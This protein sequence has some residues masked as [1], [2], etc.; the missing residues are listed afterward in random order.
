MI[1]ELGRG[2]SSKDGSALAG[3]ILEALDQIHTTGIFAT[4]LHELLQLPIQT[5]S[6]TYKKMKSSHDIATGEIVW[7]YLIEDGVCYDSRALETAREFRIEEGILQRARELQNEFDVLCRADC[8]HVNKLR[9]TQKREKFP[10]ELVKLTTE[11]FS[12]EI[13]EMTEEVEEVTDT[14][15][16]DETFEMLKSSVT[17]EADLSE[18]S[19][20]AT[21]TTTPAADRVSD[22]SLETLFSGISSY[23]GTRTGMTLFEHHESPAASFEGHSCLYLLEMRNK[24]SSAPV[25]YVGQTD[26]I[27]TRIQ[28]HRSRTFKEYGHIR[29]A[30]VRVPNTGAARLIESKIINSLKRKGIV[31]MND[32]DGKNVLFGSST[33]T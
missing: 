6:I 32:T 13:N 10:K 8:T 11:E 18:L 14:E 25:F 29:T 7:D 27:G 30:V 9:E 33:Y 24:A 15:Q 26:A 19:G 31:V 12:E 5:N 22:T 17:N 21:T 28:Q 2:T 16:P 23:I 20:T 4:H 1:D 3:S